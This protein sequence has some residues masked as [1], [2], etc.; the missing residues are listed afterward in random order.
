LR[1]H[2]RTLAAG[3]AEAELYRHE[4]EGLAEAAS[5]TADA[6]AAGDLCVWQAAIRRAAEARAAVYRPCAGDRALSRA[7][8]AQAFADWEQRH[9][10]TGGPFAWVEE[11]HILAVATPADLPRMRDVRGALFG[12]HSD[13]ALYEIERW[14]KLMRVVLLRA[15]GVA[16]PNP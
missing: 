6:L 9:R 5:T 16:D 15:A 8:L 13:E 4:L 12:R 3:G 1:A 14:D 11:R 7:Q 10:L 2:A